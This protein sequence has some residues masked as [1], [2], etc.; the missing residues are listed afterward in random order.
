MAYDL[1]STGP[2]G[3]FIHVAEMFLDFPHR[4]FPVTDADRVLGRVHLSDVFGELIRLG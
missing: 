1:I 4:V 3:D 2:E